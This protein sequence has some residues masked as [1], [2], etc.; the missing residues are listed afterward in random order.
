MGLSAHSD[1][2]SSWRSYKISMKIQCVTLRQT[3]LALISV[4]AL[5]PVSLRAAEESIAG[6]K[7]IQIYLL[8]GQ[9]NMTGRGIFGDLNK[10]AAEQKATLV[11]FIMEPQNVEKYKFL[12]KDIEK[13]G[14]SWTIRD[15]VFITL[16]DWPH[17]GQKDQGKH[18]GLGPFYGGFR[19]KG[20]G[21]EI[22][23]GHA[24]G[25]FHD[26]PVLLVK[27]AFGA[28]NLAVNFR[29]PSSGGTLGDKYPLVGKAVK[30]AIEH[31]PEII[32]GYQKENGYEIVGFFWNQGEHDCTPEF[33]AEYE[34]NLANLI[35]DLRK[36]FNAPSMKV[37][38]ATTGFGGRD[39]KDAKTA[40]TPKGYENQLKVIAAQLTLPAR[41][42]F[43][44]AAAT[45]ETRD[46]WR[47]PEHFGSNG[48]GDV[49]WNSNGESYWLI[50]EA[51]GHSMVELHKSSKK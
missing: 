25:N 36:E 49:H 8:S 7:P 27:V 46:F 48:G 35:Q 50:G 3:A 21:P 30:E 16:G 2:A 51:M 28:N 33:S 29:P 43:K 22:G 44:G 18:G 1:R 14:L 19:N 24:L 32:P 4:I 12:Y 42:E 11:R 26:E 37:V 10:P 45:V 40:A 15:D 47:A 5:F 31:L 39:P 38:I 17:E 20:F 6:K 41:P 13:K 9:S 34:Q 23:I